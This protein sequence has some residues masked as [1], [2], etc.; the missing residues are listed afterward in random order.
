MPLCSALRVKSRTD[1]GDGV[2]VLVADMTVAYKV[3]RQTF[4]SRVTLDRP[5]LKILVE[6]VD[7]PFK[8]MHNRWAFR[9][10]GE[11]ACEVEFFIDYEFASR[12][13][14]ML[15]GA[16]FDTAF[17][18]FAAAFEQ[19]ADK[20]TAASALSAMAAK[21][22]VRPAQGWRRSNRLEF[23]GL[24]LQR[25]DQCRHQHAHRRHDRRAGDRREPEFHVAPAGDVFDDHAVGAVA[26]DRLQHD[27][28]NQDRSGIAALDRDFVHAVKGK[29][30]V[31]APPPI[32]N[33]QR[34]VAIRRR[35]RAAAELGRNQHRAQRIGDAAA[36]GVG[37]R[38]AIGVHRRLR[39]DRLGRDAVGEGHLQFDGAVV[40]GDGGR[41]RR[42][43]EAVGRDTALRRDRAFAVHQHAEH[44]ARLA[45]CGRG[46][47]R[48]ADGDL[49]GDLAD[50]DPGHRDRVVRR[51]LALRV[52][53]ICGEQSADQRGQELGCHA[54]RY[55]RSFAIMVSAM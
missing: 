55:L 20:S 49:P 54:K 29:R 25:P 33:L 15:M 18:K 30:Q 40:V 28:A 21:A 24:D 26:G 43:I 51:E 2:T 31:I 10:T 9:P 36:V 23:I 1:K 47:E 6:Y 11:H 34:A 45:G 44:A 16:M 7:G 37:H 46:V 4:T 19:R 5:N 13:L 17:R 14:G 8:H 3:I 50:R 42:R 52:R 41:V 38:Q 48:V 35:Q 39:R 32:E 53:R 27:A 12:T 22:R